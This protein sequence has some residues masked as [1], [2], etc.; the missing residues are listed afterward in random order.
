MLLFLNKEVKS[1]FEIGNKLHNTILKK[2]IL[3]CMNYKYTQLD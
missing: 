2:K 3:I 1:A